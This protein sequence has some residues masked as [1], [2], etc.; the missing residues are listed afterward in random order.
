[1]PVVETIEDA[2]HGPDP[3][4]G[5]LKGDEVLFR[6]MMKVTYT[7]GSGMLPLPPWVTAVAV[8][9]C[10]GG[11]GGAAGGRVSTFQGKAGAPGVMAANFA[12][13]SP[14]VDRVIEFSVGAG[15]AGGSGYKAGVYD[16]NPGADGGPST[17]SG[18][19]SASGPGGA[20]G[21]GSAKTASAPT[22]P[23]VAQRGK[24]PTPLNPP[25]PWPERLNNEASPGPASAG[26]GGNGGFG[27]T[28]SNSKQ[29]GTRGIDG[30][31]TV[32]A[33]GWME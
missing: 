3:V 16:G 25:A 20:G 23:V 22:T 29:R 33:W 4:S 7:S 11:G 8:V 9:V 5:L 21:N 27:A 14:G 10:G 31:I 24:S 13:V 17:V 30:F 12:V 15:G 2:W 28:S 1:M 18:A 6:R 19:V 32:Y 26:T